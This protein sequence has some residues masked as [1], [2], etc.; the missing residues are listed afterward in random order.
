[1]DK[2]RPSDGYVSGLFFTSNN[3]I[4]LYFFCYR[5]ENKVLYDKIVMN[6]DKLTLMK[7]IF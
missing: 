5:T 6:D 4:I 1:M 2:T 3:N 7:S